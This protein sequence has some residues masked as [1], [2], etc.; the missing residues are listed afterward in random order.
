MFTRMVQV[1]NLTGAT[2]IIVCNIPYPKS[3]IANYTNFTC[4]V[5]PTPFS[6]FVETLKKTSAVFIVPI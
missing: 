3:T 5:H 2:K 1:Y 4:S 6:L